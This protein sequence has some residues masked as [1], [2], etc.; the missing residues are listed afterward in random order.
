MGERTSYLPGTPSWVDLGSPDPAAAAE[1]YGEVF[2]WTA[3]AG[4]QSEEE[5][6][7][8]EPGEAPEAGSE[9]YLVDGKVTCGAHT[10]GDGEFPSWSVWFAV[11]DC[12]ASAAQIT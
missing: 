5:A 11:A 1:F 2:G 8:P 7:P 10:A 4:G 12:D 9:I 6:E 3:A